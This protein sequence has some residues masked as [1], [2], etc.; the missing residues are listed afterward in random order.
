MP[1][2]PKSIYR[3]NTNPIQIPVTYC[4]DIEQI[5]QKLIWNHKGLRIASTPLRKKNKVG[6]ITIPDIKLLL[7]GHCNQNSLVL[8]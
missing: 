5:F 1:I 4:T 8:I 7:Q 3:F 2:L 6:G